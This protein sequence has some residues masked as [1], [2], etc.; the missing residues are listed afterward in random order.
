MWLTTG[1]TRGTTK[2]AY[3]TTKWLNKICGTENLW[4]LR[5]ILKSRDA[6]NRVSTF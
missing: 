4:K 1:A 3:P 6:I 2:D 5:V